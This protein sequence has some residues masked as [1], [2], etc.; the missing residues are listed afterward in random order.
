MKKKKYLVKFV[1]LS[2]R[3][4]YPAT[5]EEYL[6]SAFAEMT[7]RGEEIVSLSRSRGE[8]LVLLR[9]N[10]AGSGIGKDDREK[11]MS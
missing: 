2:D 7:A 5:D 1:P 9:T 10:P 4:P 8:L 6:E 3:P 11:R